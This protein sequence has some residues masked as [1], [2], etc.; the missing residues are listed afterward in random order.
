MTQSKARTGLVP[1]GRADRNRPCSYD[2]RGKGTDP[3]ATIQM[4][5]GTDLVS[6]MAEAKEQTILLQF[7]CYGEHILFL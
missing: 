2:G 5:L 6:T 4:L 1:N 3:S 7:R